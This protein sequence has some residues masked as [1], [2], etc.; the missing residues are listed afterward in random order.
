VTRAAIPTD[1]FCAA[2]L[3]DR[4]AIALLLQL[5]QP[6]IRRY[7]RTACRTA[8][9]A[10]DAAQEALWLLYRH[11]GA[12]RTLLAFPAWLGKVVTRE[13]IRL[14]R[15]AD[16]SLP[17]A[18]NDHALGLDRSDTDLRL[19]VAAAFES[20]PAHYRDVALMRDVKELTIEEIATALDLTRETVKARLHRARQMTREFLM[21]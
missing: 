1:I 7:A 15:K 19:D 9:D 10:E 17:L 3:G 14:A 18:D 20:L 11:V 5:A 12:I 6:D 21:R 4:D 2:Q 16:L 8:S 13:C